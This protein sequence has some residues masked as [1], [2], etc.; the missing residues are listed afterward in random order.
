M[1]K[2]VR[3]LVSLIM[4]SVFFCGSVQAA[5]YPTYTLGP[6]ET[7][8]LT[9]SAY[10]SDGTLNLDVQNAEDLFYDE[11]AN[12]IYVADTGNKRILTITPDGNVTG[13][14]GGNVLKKPTGI[15]VKDGKVYVA[16]KEAQEIF[17]FH[18]TGKLIRRIGRPRSAIYGKNSKFVPT[19]VG[20][21]TRGNIYCV[22]EGNENGVLQFTNTGAFFGYVGAN[23]TTVSITTVLRNIFLSEKQKETMMKAAPTSPTSL[24]INHQGLLYTVTNSAENEAVKKLNTMG[25]TI[26]ALNSG[27]ESMDVAT[28]A[29]DNMFVLDEEG[30]VAVYDSY[31]DLLFRFGGKDLNYE[32]LGFLKNPAGIDIMPDR[33]ILVLDKDTHMILIYKPTEFAEMVFQGTALYKD[34]LYVESKEIWENI[35]KLNSSFL[36][37][38]KVIGNAN[39]KEHHYD[40]ALHQFQTAEYKEGYSDAFWQLRN[41]WLRN[42]A[43]TAILIIVFLIILWQVLRQMNRRTKILKPAIE[44]LHKF[45]RLKLIKQL[46]F[47]KFM[48]RH[49]IDGYYEIKWKKSC[50]AVSAG[51]LLLWY[52]IINILGVFFIGYLFQS[53][54]QYSVELLPLMAMRVLPILLF[55]CANYLVSTISDGEGT[56]KEVF[57]STIYGL[58]PYLLIMPVLIVVS[59]VLTYNEQFVYDYSMIIIYVWCAV[60]LYLMVREIHNY[61]EGEC[62]KNIFVTLFAMAIIVLFVFVIYL[63]FHQESDYI[64]SL[65]KEASYIYGK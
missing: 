10:E 51:I 25:N 39:V 55:I 60:N 53:T 47:T 17:I 20:V 35:L 24:S 50:S 40:E 49:P 15:A 37:S 61:G 48:L 26:V 30:Y 6:E 58:S 31:G 23:S 45:E 28:D 59:N 2:I 65:V 63:L 11:D 56:L 18:R 64:V 8:I 7:Q 46:K 32:R 38:Y 5:S 14:F 36:L 34:G 44:T 22:S 43:G 52:I 27:A 19:K 41:D 16:D 62:I 54:D 4:I 1:K 12:I 3:L 33:R 21:D 13:E 9:Q 29:D 42:H 57:I